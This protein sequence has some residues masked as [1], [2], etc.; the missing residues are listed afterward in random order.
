MGLKNRVVIS[1]VLAALLAVAGAAA[2]QKQQPEPA[3]IVRLKPA[4]FP[5]LPAAVRED[6]ERRGCLIPQT[7]AAKHPE[8]VISG[9][10][11]DGSG[12][13]WA[14][15][16]SRAGFSSVLVFW[17]G[18]AQMPDEL[19]ESRDMD[20]IQT[21]DRSGVFGYS[22]L[23][24]TAPPSEIGKREGNKQ[25]GPFDHDGIDD[26]FLEKGSAIHY[27]RRGQWERLE[28]AD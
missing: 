3:K 5:E 19:A 15:L 21:Y 14:V 10:F 20:S 13:D 1:A 8:N 12:G 23:I 28:G 6:L 17:S 18:S 2:R 25:L 11:R 24:I 22:R 27:F 7:F 4:E 9:K 16:C 26:G